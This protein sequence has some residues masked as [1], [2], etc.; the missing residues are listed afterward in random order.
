MLMWSQFY[1]ILL[2]LIFLCFELHFRLCVK[3]MLFEYR[4]E[5]KIKLHM[6]S[7]SKWQVNNYFSAKNNFFRE[8]FWT[9]NLKLYQINKTF[10]KSLNSVTFIGLDHTRP[11]TQWGCK[12]SGGSHSEFG[13]LTAFRFWIVNHPRL[14]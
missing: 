9:R 5:R 12:Y 3:L 10:I 4:F 13:W 7:C 11:I 6:S 8:L 2:L 1:M 14:F